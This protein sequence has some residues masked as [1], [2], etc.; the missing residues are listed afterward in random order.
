MLLG[1]P[2]TISAAFPVLQRQL[3]AIGLDIQPVKSKIWAP[4][5]WTATVA[6]PEGLSITEEGTTVLGVPLG[7]SDFTER[8]MTLALGK[9]CRQL[10]LLPELHDPQ[11]ATLLLTRCFAARPLYL[12]RS[13]PP[14]IPLLALDKE[15][16]MGL[17]TALTSIIGVPSPL[18]NALRSQIHLP[19][20]KGGLVL[21]LLRPWLHLPML[22]R[23]WRWC[24]DFWLLLGKRLGR[25]SRRLSPL[26]P[27]CVSPFSMPWWRPELVY[28]R[29]C[30]WLSPVFVPASLLW[31]L[32]S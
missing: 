3:H 11:V 22:R 8:A 16:D 17:E 1:T 4:Q 25:S 29:L 14:T 30:K 2:A 32:S 31:R 13:L 28:R 10:E 19:I 24:L 27:T 26:R 12:L 23:G 6:I 15:H 9:S 20:S 7:T 18:D 21:S 5:G